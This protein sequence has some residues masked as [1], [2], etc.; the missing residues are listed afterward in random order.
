MVC[1][2]M[3]VE[4]LD[5]TRDPLSLCSLAAGVCYG[6]RDVKPSRA[7]SCLRRGH[8]SVLEHAKATW[9]V[10]GVSRVCMA[11][12]TRH[13][14]ASYSVESQRY[15]EYGQQVE[16]VVPPDLHQDQR[17]AFTL[18]CD[19]ALREYREAVEG[20]ARPEDARMLLPGAM[21]T[22]MVLTMDAREV[23][24]FMRLRLDG[25]AQW[26]VRRLA[27]EMRRTLSESCAEWRELLDAGLDG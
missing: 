24:A 23:L 4:L 21:P 18:A 26:E 17:Y 13:R 6:K 2:P 1:M 15:V 10:E 5:A 20:G 19:A 9:L 11:Q 16:F 3:R 7:L 27:G 25:A 12:V 14:L 22:S 8:G